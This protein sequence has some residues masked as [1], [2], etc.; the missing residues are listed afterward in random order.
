MKRVLVVLV[1]M[2]CGGDDG[3]TVV[4]GEPVSM[5]EGQELCD[6]FAAHATS[7]GWGG[8]VNQYDWNCGDASIVWRDDAMRVF[9][10]CATELVC[11]GDGASCQSETAAAITPLDYHQTYAT[12]CETRMAECG[13]GAT[14][15]S[16][17]AWELYTRAIVTELTA[18]MDAACGDIATCISA[19]L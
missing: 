2:G 18:C 6:A 16:V 1:V 12:K 10:D 14:L 3:G 13:V 9:A 11:T 8:N 19:T 4:G 17:D 15:C 5:A 7:C